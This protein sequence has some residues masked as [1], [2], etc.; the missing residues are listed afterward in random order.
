[1]A[2]PWRFG[3]LA[4]QTGLA[5]A[6]ERSLLAGIL[7]A[8]R[9]INESGGIAGRP[10]QALAYDPGGQPERY[11][12]YGRQLLNEDAC[13]VIFG[14]YMSSQR[15]AVLP[16][17]RAHDALLCY[18]T[19]YEGFEYSDNVFYAG[20]APNQN[21]LQLANYMI[22]A[23]GDTICIVG[24]DY[25]FPREAS[26]I[27]REVLE[28]SGGRV[29]SEV[30]LPLDASGEDFKPVVE[31]IRALRPSAIFSTLVGESI[32]PFC[33][34]LES[35]SAGRQ[36][37]PVGSLNTSEA[38]LAQ[39]RPEAIEGHVMSM[40]YFSTIRGETNERFLRNYRKLAGHKN[41][42]TSC[43]EAA[44]F[45]VHMVAQAIRKTGSA[46]RRT[47]LEALR[48]VT[49]EAPQ[50]L[51]RMDSDNNHSYLWPRIGMVNS[52][53]EIAIV[54]DAPDA[55]KPDPYL[56]LPSLTP[57]PPLHEAERSPAQ[58]Y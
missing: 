56:M 23:F 1:M 10:I 45:Q 58:E 25:I 43:S 16:D 7:L 22:D 53:G 38:E 41:V 13:S 35:A 14:C 37:I 55:V 46:D 20:A 9:E 21:N 2:E 52:R 6:S 11:A 50:G 51:V 5:G 47:L 18:P 29:L 54:R 34:A 4:S 33:H 8:I 17:L 31:T 57:D 49:C 27:F 3:I 48:H 36:R 19:M 12:H 26:R 39:I 24:S 42:P 15:K 44:Y 28:A 40:P 32:I 30:F